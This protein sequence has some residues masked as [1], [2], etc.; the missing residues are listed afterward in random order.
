MFPINMAI[1][2]ATK[3]KRK[4]KRG[5]GRAEAPPG[6]SLQV[7]TELLRQ[8]KAAVRGAGE[9][10]G[11]R[12]QQHVMLEEIR[13]QLVLE[14]DSPSG[15]T[16]LKALQ[17]LDTLFLR[18]P[19]FRALAC[20][21]LRALVSCAQTDLGSGGSRQLPGVAR[22]SRREPPKDHRAEVKAAALRMLEVW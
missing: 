11:G 7:D 15:A 19:A 16:R 1:T 12:Q 10:K 17:L 3:V 9:G 14:L 22:G 5:D 2:E 4:R 21:D 13:R 18:V 8:L 6:P 20:Q